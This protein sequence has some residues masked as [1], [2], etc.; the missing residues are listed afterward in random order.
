MQNDGHLTDGS[1]LRLI[2]LLVVLIQP[3]LAAVLSCPKTSVARAK[4]NEEC[5]KKNTTPKKLFKKV[6]DT[7][8]PLSP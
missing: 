7:H 1:R 6:S 4:T 5:E 2:I 8:T 3:A